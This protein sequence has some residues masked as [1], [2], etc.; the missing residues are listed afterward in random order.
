MVQLV[1]RLMLFSSMALAQSIQPGIWQADST[2]V[3]NGLALP[4]SQQNDCVTASDAKDIKKTIMKELEKKGCAPLK[5]IVKDQQIEVSLL[6]A[7]SGLEA[8]GN[9][10]G[11]VN[12]KNYQLSG[13]AEGT[14]EGIPSHANIELKGKWMKSCAK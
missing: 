2:L 14:Y 9:L 4:S 12:S 5:W 11:S 8:K 13:E 3:I 6:C 1:F 10:H 7:K